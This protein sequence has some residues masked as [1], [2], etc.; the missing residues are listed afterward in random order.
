MTGVMLRVF[1]M[2][3]LSLACF[4]M[5][6]SGRDVSSAPAPTAIRDAKKVFLTNSRA[7][8]LAYGAFYSAIEAWGRYQIVGSRDEADLVV[9]LAYR[10]GQGRTWLHDED[11]DRRH[12]LLA[13]TTLTILD[14]R[15]HK[16]LWSAVNRER[17]AIREK[18]R[19]KDAV[20]SA[21]R[22]VEKW[23]IAVKVPR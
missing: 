4:A 19:Q 17:L 23:K 6:A 8:D 10:V 7:C 12:P 20:N 15:S 1:S 5:P 22:L 9:E 3:C 18:N 11:Y 14:A 21:Q 16:R 2:G 13:T